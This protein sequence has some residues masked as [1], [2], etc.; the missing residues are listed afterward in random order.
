MI[1]SVNLRSTTA[2]AHAVFV[3]FCGSNWPM[4][5]ADARASASKSTGDAWPAAANA[6]AVFAR[7]CGL[8]WPILAA[9]ARASASKSAG[10][11][12]PAVANAH[13]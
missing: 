8:N 13:A 11:A 2:N 3:R 1:S 7:S 6:H 12:W 4:L 10:D 9:D 5:A